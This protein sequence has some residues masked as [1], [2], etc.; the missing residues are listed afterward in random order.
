VI[1]FS[2][3]KA[4]RG[5]RG[6][7]KITTLGVRLF[8]QGSLENSEM[9]ASKTPSRKCTITS[10]HDPYADKAM[11]ALFSG[12]PTHRKSARHLKNWA[13]KASL[14]KDTY[15]EGVGKVGIRRKGDK[16]IREVVVEKK[17]SL[18]VKGEMKTFTKIEKK[19]FDGRHGTIPMKSYP[20]DRDS[21][22]RAMWETLER[23][24]ET[25]VLEN[26]VEDA[27]DY[28]NSVDRI[29]EPPGF[30]KI[31]GTSRKGKTEMMNAYPGRAVY[32]GTITIKKESGVVDRELDDW[33]VQTWDWDERTT[34]KIKEIRPQSA[35]ITNLKKSQRFGRDRLSTPSRF[36]RLGEMTE[37]EARK[38]YPDQKMYR[39]MKA[40]PGEDVGGRGKIDL[41]T[42]TYSQ[43]DPSLFEWVV[44]EPVSALRKNLS[45]NPNGV[46][47]LAPAR[48]IRASLSPSPGDPLPAYEYS[49]YVREKM[50]L[51][52]VPKTKWDEKKVLAYARD[53]EDELI[54]IVQ[55]RM[56]R[57]KEEVK[58]EIR[59]SMVERGVKDK[60][61]YTRENDSRERDF[62]T[63]YWKQGGM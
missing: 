56:D 50:C 27:K 35:P 11:R 42:L 58:E 49:D 47:K 48:Y 12:K 63:L 4:R 44:E 3:K 14:P 18:R 51:L 46:L 39:L 20:V 10:M 62:K 57:T 40:L 24:T 7:E 16:M 55:D 5:E 15:V 29:S 59:A 41:D 53:S 31:K 36:R 23:P 13:N 60:S 19:V 33:R 54:R 22:G 26:K 45:Y 37:E 32:Q 38:Q 8:P 61:S 52:S 6:G 43:K 30:V 9:F 21:V 25:V 1:S 2:F 17:K 28:L 34:K